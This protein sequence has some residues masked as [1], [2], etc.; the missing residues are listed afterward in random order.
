MFAGVLDTPRF[1]KHYKYMMLI[2]L[3][4]FCY[5]KAVEFQEISGVL[6]S[7]IFTDHKISFVI[8]VIHDVRKLRIWPHLLKKSLEENVIL[9]GLN[10]NCCPLN[11]R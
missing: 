11:C 8:Y 4:V 5:E 1:S 2:N 9:C 7:V 10:S 6:F 3:I